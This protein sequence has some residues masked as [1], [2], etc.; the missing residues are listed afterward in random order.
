MNSKKHMDPYLLIFKHL[1]IMRHQNNKREITLDGMLTV[2]KLENSLRV[3]A[4]EC[5]EDVEVE[6]FI[7][8]FKVQGMRDGNVYMEELPK[9]FRNE[10]L[11]RLNNSS[12]TLGRDGMYYYRFR[13]P[14]SELEQ[15]PNI[16][17]RESRQI[18]TKVR[19]TIINKE[20]A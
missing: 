12:F 19:K 18:A 4:F 2:G 7:G 11:F 16:L 14:E 10:P 17:L 13:L 15:L 1:I 9:R 6:A 8:R 20:E 3:A 5:C